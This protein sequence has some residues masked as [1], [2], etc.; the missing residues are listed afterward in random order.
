M[1]VLYL[2]PLGGRD[3]D[4]I[5]KNGLCFEEWNPDSFLLPILG[6]FIKAGLSITIITLSNI[7]SFSIETTGFSMK[8]IKRFKH[9]NLSALLGFQREIKSIEKAIREVDY[10]VIHAH[11]CYEYAMAAILVCRE[12]TVITLHDWPDAINNFFKSF[13]WNARLGLGRKVIKKAKNIIAV[14]PYIK[15]LADDYCPRAETKVIPNFL[16]MDFFID[17]VKED[18]FLN[19]MDEFRFISVS[20]STKRKNI[21]STIKAFYEVLKKGYNVKLTLIGPGLGTDGKIY[22]WAVEERIAYNISF[23][24]PQ[25]RSV[26]SQRISEAD[27]LVHTS[28]EESFGMTLIE[29]MAKGTLFLAGESTG[30][31]EWIADYGRAGYLVDITNVKDISDEM[32]RIIDLGGATRYEKACYALTFAR[33][34]FSMNKIAKDTLSLYRDIQGNQK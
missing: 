18:K 32:I 17:K 30:G 5:K 29:S 3:V 19:R 26:V 31:P 14:S 28:F 24:G 12:K 6:N 22:A 25:N 13:Y 15:R 11:W 34:N 2:L 7:D 10:D 23:L 8:N 16:P 4:Y 9:G 21:K 27:L 33:E 1:K 20:D